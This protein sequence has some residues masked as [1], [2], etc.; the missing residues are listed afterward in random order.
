MRKI[1]KDM[2]LAVAQMVGPTPPTKRLGD[3]PIGGGIIRLGEAC[4]LCS[5][6]NLWSERQ[7]KK[8][9]KDMEGIN[10]L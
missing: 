1:W 8:R 4:P 6:I 2:I 10:T 5:P 9:K 3:G 7:K